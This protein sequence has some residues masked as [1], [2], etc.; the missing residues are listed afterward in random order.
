MKKLLI[1]LLAVVM[2]VASAGSSSAAGVSIGGGIHYLRNVNDI[3][4]SGVDLDKN[5]VGLVGSILGDVKVLKL[6]GQLEYIN[7]YAGSDESMWIPQAWAMIGSLLY[8]GAGIG[9]G[10]IDGD[11]QDDPFYGLRAGLNIPLGAVNL[12]TYGTYHFWN[13]DAFAEVTEEDLDSVTFAALL[14]FDLGG[15]DDDDHD[16]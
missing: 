5:S 7:N 6:E 12:D 2:V 10:H 13:D 16:E 8:A 4:G 3:D 14:R 1:A 11:W 9:I 15:G